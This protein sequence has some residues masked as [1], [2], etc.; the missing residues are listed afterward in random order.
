[1]GIWKASLV[2][3][4]LYLIWSTI[5]YVILLQTD[6]FENVRERVNLLLKKK[7]WKLF[8]WL[9]RKL[10]SRSIKI[11]PWWIAVVFI[12]E[13]PLTGVPMIRL[14]FPQK[15]WIAGMMWV[16]F[17]CAL[18]VVSWY[19]PLYGGLFLLLKKFALTL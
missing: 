2:D 8:I 15:K 7:N 6:S 9:R 11:S 10:R 14:M 4:F 19:L 12:V 3:F 5:F 18:E 17:G 13:S 1:M 16:I